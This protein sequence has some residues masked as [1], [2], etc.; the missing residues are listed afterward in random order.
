MCI[1]APP[2]SVRRMKKL[3]LRFLQW[4]L[5]QW[6]IKTGPASTRIKLCLR[7]TA[8][9]RNKHNG[10]Y[11]IMIVIE[12]TRKCGFSAMFEGHAKCSS[13]RICCHSS[14]DLITLSIYRLSIKLFIRQNIKIFL[15]R[16]RHVKIP[17]A[18]G[19]AH[20]VTHQLQ[21]AI[22]HCCIGIGYGSQGSKDAKTNSTASS[23]SV[24][25]SETTIATKLAREV[26]ATL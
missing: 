26:S 24:F 5:V 15:W 16:N 6:R 2:S 21:H 4:V 3:Y 25:R 14:S 19:I 18:N 23:A 1:T 13:V 10:K 17:Y 12:G 11:R 7:Q 22:C 20:H 8:P 9:H